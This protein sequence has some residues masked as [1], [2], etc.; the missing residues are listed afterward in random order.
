ME[1]NQV[2][3]HKSYVSPLSKTPTKYNNG[4]TTGRTPTK[5]KPN[6]IKTSGMAK[7]P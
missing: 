5:Y 6:V 7:N 1:K 2:E 4:N 3:P